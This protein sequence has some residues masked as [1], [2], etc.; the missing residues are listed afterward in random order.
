MS[1]LRSASLLAVGLCA[2]VLSSFGLSAIAAKDSSNVPIAEVQQFARSFNAIKQYYVDPVEDKN[3]MINATKGMV[4]GLDPHSEFLDEKGYKNM[5]ESTQGSFGGLG[6]EVTKDSAGVLV[7][8]PIDETPAA[9]AGIRPGDII[10]KINGVTTDDQSLD[11]SVK[12]MRGDPNTEIELTIARKGVNKPMVMKLTRAIIKVKSVKMKKLADGIGYI[13]ISQFQERTGADLVA[14]L[15]Q[16]AKDKSLKGLVLDLRNDPGGVLQSAVAVAGAFLPPNSEVVSTKGRTPDSNYSYKVTPEDYFL[17]DQN[18][19]ILQDLTPEAKSVPIVVLIN[20]ATASASE[21]VSG[22]LQ[23]YHRATLMGNRSFGKGSVQTILPMRTGDKVVGIKLTT[24]RY[25]TPSGR[26]I[27][28]K[29][30]EPDIYVDDTPKGN[31]PS[32]QIRESDLKHHLSSKEEENTNAKDDLPY[33]GDDGVAPDYQFTMGDEK[34]WQLQQAVNYL[35]GKPVEVSQYRGK[36][37][38]IVEKLKKAEEKAKKEA[39]E[40]TEKVE[41]ADKVSPVDKVEEPNTST[42]ENKPN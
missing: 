39:G 32:F 6:I 23:D 3:L 16:L 26:S 10:T 1:K 34:D 19:D 41:Q 25:Y 21:I 37:R 42:Q 5:T 40:Q 7:V 30:I 15:N 11:A 24:T 12:L 9:R 13:R 17:S 8:S 20:S 33:D 18:P 31:Y 22:A 4:S 35:T 38:K 2:G 14:N 36:P 28:A 27:Q 29:G